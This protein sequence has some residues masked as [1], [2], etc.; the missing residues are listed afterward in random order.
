MLAQSFWEGIVE[1]SDSP[2]FIALLC[3]VA[4]AVIAIVVLLFLLFLPFRLTLHL[5][6]SQTKT[7]RH[8]GHQGVELHEPAP[9]EGYRFVGWFEDKLFIR[10][11]DKVYRMPM[12]AAHLYAKWEAV[13]EEQTEEPPV[14]AAEETAARNAA[15]AAPA[16]ATQN[17]P[18]PAEEQPAAPAAEEAVAQEEELVSASAEEQPAAPAAEEAVAQEEE[19]VSAPA[20]EQPA[21]AEEEEVPEDEQAEESG[22]GDEIEGALVT[23]VSGGKVFVQYRRSYT[24]RLIQ[25]DDAIKDFYNGIRNE[26]LS[27]IGVKERVSWNYH[28]FNVG[29]RQFAKINANTKSLILYLALDPGEVSEKY[30]FRDVSEKKRYAS[31]PVRYKITGSRSYRYALELLEQTAA[32]FALDFHRKEDTQVIPYEDR[33]ALIRRGL[34]KVY[35][36]RD[37]GETVTEEQ[38]E[39]MIAEGATVEK[40]SAYTVTDRVSV[41]EAEDLITDATAEQLIAL[42]DTRVERIVPGRRA[43]VNLDT[44]SANYREGEKVDLASLKAKGLIDKKAAACKVLARGMLDKSLT[45]EAADFSLPAVKMIALTGGKVIRIRKDQT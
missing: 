24:A 4:L 26:V 8:F 16:A 33:D 27:Y 10:P 29:R 28:S 15:D 21:A 30:N 41:K 38:L 9:R 14:V 18:A 13:T 11:V 3:I 19:L 6:G 1:R 23:P 34:I 37:T 22:E 40:L 7:E 20:E 44:I 5:D 42:A 12:R 2:A 32:K 36:K 43:V 35:A 45:I 25:A 17:I 39:E 31:V